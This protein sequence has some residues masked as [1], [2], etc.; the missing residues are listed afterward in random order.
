MGNSFFCAIYMFLHMVLRRRVLE[1]IYGIDA[2]LTRIKKGA[3]WC[4]SCSKCRLIWYLTSAIKLGDPYKIVESNDLLNGLGLNFE[5]STNVMGY[6][7]E[8]KAWV[9]G[10]EPEGGV[11]EEISAV[12][13]IQRW[14][15][16]QLTP[17][18]LDALKTTPADLRWM[19]EI[20]RASVLEV[21]GDY[22]TALQDYRRALKIMPRWLPEAKVVFEKINE[23]GHRGQSDN[24]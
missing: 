18:D 21:H 12:H 14:K 16:R 7:K 22:E 19:L 17:C 5:S 8:S 11:P 24:E 13:L 23:F 10:G 1:D 20:V 3:S 9:G 2:G 4:V 15:L 6:I